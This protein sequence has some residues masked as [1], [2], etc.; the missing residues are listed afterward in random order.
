[1]AEALLQSKLDAIGFPARVHSAGTLPWRGPASDGAQSAMEDH[2]VD[3]SEHESQPLSD[4]MVRDADLILGM[5]RSHVWTVT[6]HVP[7]AAERAF[8]I[9]ELARLGERVGPRAR[10]EA[11]RDW[12]ARVAATRTDPRIPGQ[13]SDEIADPAGESVTIYRAT[14]NRLDRE[15]DRVVALITGS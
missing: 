7:P 13:S 14:A 2:G 10:D 15:L 6:T 1:M 5:T 12:A 11:V 4:A 9:G 8:L 3:L